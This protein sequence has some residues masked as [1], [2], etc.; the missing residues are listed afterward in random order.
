MKSKLTFIFTA[1]AILCF[2]FAFT[3]SMA[4]SPQGGEGIIPRNTEPCLTEAQRADIKRSIDDN[5]EQLKAAGTYQ[6]IDRSG[7]HPLFNWPVAQAGGFDYHSVWALSNYVDHDPNFPNQISDYECGTRSYDTT[8]GYNHK[9]FDII[10]WPFWWHQM[11][12]DQAINV[13]A[14][15]GQILDKRDGAFDRNCGFNNLV[16]NFIAIQHSDGSVTCYLHM[17]NGG[18]TSKVIGDSVT[19]GEFLGVIGSSGSSTVPHLHFEVYD[20]ANNLID[21]SMG[22]CNNFNADTWWNV[23]KPYYTPGINAV[24]THSATPEFPTCPTSEVT[25]ESNQFDMGDTVYYGLFLRDQQAGSSIHLKITR[26]DSSVF[27]EWDYSLADYFSIS[28]WL[29]S[30]PAD[31]DGTWT[32][33]A[34]YMGDTATHTYNVG[35]LGVQDNELVNTVVYP[36]PL[37]DKLFIESESQINKVV[38][39]DLLG[40]TVI[41]LNDS[42]NSIS[43]VDVASLHEGIYFVTLTSEANQTKTIKLVKN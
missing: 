13:A 2:N 11:D 42:A 8:A 3:Q 10:S 23:Q 4:D 14:A 31:M 12:S 35:V 9:G 20:S 43:E 41:E 33:E 6:D 34:T 29:W 7:G 24:L 5:I 38:L 30:F 40:R 19:Q 21:P 36:N 27:Q 22:A 17:K 18:L 26:P 16:P 25:H 1:L 28:W 37:K 39:R 32:W 15:D